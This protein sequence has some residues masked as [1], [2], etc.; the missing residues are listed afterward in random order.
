MTNEGIILLVEDDVDLNDANRRTLELRH[1][2]VQTALTLERAREILHDIEPDIIL[3]DVTLPDGNGFSFCR[4]IRE[5]TQAH[6]LFLTAKNEHEDMVRG[7]TTGG[8]DYIIKPFHADELLARVEATMRRREIGVPVKTLSK[9]LLTLDILA[10]QGLVDGK[11]L[12]L[13]QKEFAV[14]LLFVQNEGKTLS[15]EN[16]YERVW[17]T[18]MAGDNQ[19]VQ[20]AVSRLRKKLETAGYEI[21]AVR[22]Q[23]YVF[24]KI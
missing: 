3:L 11:D 18:T 21:R 16:V 6:I 1:Y 12:N 9:G 10:L 7:L 4:E 19:A 23:G 17:G 22:G 13:T 8:D 15:T 2:T 24:E 5:K 20:T 14:L